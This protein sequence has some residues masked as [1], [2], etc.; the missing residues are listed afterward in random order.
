MSGPL[1][2]SLYSALSPPWDTLAT[3]FL[4]FYFAMIVILL[5]RTGLWAVFSI[6]VMNSGTGSWT[7]IATTIV[8]FFVLVPAGVIYFMSQ[9]N[10]LGV[11]I[12]SLIRLVLSFIIMLFVAGVKPKDKETIKK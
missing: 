12:L 10:F 2:Y 6:M 7:N 4:E 11:A 9:E 3:Y 5:V 1:P 8:G